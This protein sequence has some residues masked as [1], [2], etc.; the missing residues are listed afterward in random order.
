MLNECWGCGY[1][2]PVKTLVG[3]D[4]Q[5]C[6]VIRVLLVAVRRGLA[7]PENCRY[8]DTIAVCYSSVDSKLTC[9]YNDHS[10]YVWDV[11]DIKKIGKA[12]SFLFHSG[13]IWGIDVSYLQ[14]V[15]ALVVCVTCKPAT[16]CIYWYAWNEPVQLAGF[17]TKLWI[18]D[19]WI[20]WNLINSFRKSR[21]LFAGAMPT[22]RAAHF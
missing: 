6:L 2:A 4:L 18:L 7:V 3:N 16:Y 12:R 13:A 9:I 21:L 1:F 19:G 14:L 5:S 20:L 15:S 10:L 22:V 11:A 17:L 8:P